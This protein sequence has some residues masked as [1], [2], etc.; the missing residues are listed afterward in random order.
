MRTNSVWKAKLKNIGKSYRTCTVAK[1]RC[2]LSGMTDRQIKN[3]EKAGITVDLTDDGAKNPVT[4]KS[5]IK[6]LTFKDNAGNDVVIK[7]QSDIG[8]LR[9]DSSIR[10]QLRRAYN[11]IFYSIWDKTGGKPFAK[12]KLSR[13]DKLKGDTPD[14]LKKS[15]DTAMDGRN[16][17]LE[18]DAKAVADDDP[19][20]AKKLAQNAEAEKTATKIKTSGGFGSVFKGGA[21]GIGVLG[22]VDNACTVLNTSLIVESGAKVIR[23]AQLAS[24]ASIFLTVADQQK[25]SSPT[26]TAEKASFVGERTYRDRH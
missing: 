22:A 2:G 3:F 6:S 8:K 26:L 11:P 23:A 20:K 25:A 7:N 5:G 15:F 21:K 19:E 18:A 1:F 16:A 24:Y 10:S 12:Y 13:A 9:L 14:E 4:R 17:N